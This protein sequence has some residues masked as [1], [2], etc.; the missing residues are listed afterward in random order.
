MGGF[1]LELTKDPKERVPLDWFN[2]LLGTLFM[3]AGSYLLSTKYSEIVYE[4]DTLRLFG[5][6]SFNPF[7]DRWEFENPLA[8]I[9]GFIGHYQYLEHLQ[10]M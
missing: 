3:G 1:E 8:F 6:L 5:M 7:C 2:R 10:T 4:G 9:K